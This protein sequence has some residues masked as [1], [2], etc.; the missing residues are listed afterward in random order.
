MFKRAIFFAAL[1]SGALALGAPSAAETKRTWRGYVAAEARAFNGDTQASIV[2]EPEFEVRWDAGAQRFGAKL[3]FRLDS[4]DNERTHF[5]ARE[6]FW[7]GAGSTWELRAGISK[8]FWGVTESQHLVDVINQT[9]L[10][11]NPDGEDKL[12]QPMVKFSSIRNWGIV[13]VFLLPGFRERTFPSIDGRLVGPLPVD[14]DSASY[15]SSAGD[16]HLDAAVRWS[17]SIG[18]F[19]LGFA[20]FSGTNREPKLRPNGAVLEP[21][22][23]QMSQASI[24]LQATVGSWLLKLESIR[25]ED[26]IETFGAA[27]AGLEYT[28]WGAGSSAIDI[29]VLVEYLWDERGRLAP[30]PFDDDWFVGSRLAFNDA[31]DSSILAGIIFDPATNARAGL[32]EARRR[33]GKNWIVELELRTFRGGNSPGFIDSIATDDYLVVGVQR[34]F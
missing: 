21:F 27:T 20:V 9:D 32:I 19:D 5:D 33:L 1:L 24:D 8:V 26:S 15:E 18:V 28:F 6:L 17:H 22:Y 10:V 34:H 23:D 7:E 25:R 11:E 30:T 16:R 14:T 29:G 3:F 2:A 31:A 13:D 4:L 12:G